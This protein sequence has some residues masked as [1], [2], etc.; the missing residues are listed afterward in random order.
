MSMIEPLMRNSTLLVDKNFKFVGLFDPGN[1]LL[2]S[3]PLSDYR[4]SS[5]VYLDGTDQH[6]Q[7]IVALY[8]HFR[9]TFLSLIKCHLSQL[10]SFKQLGS[11]KI[12]MQ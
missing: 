1:N 6:N 11:I 12:K 4:T 5:L 3:L 10:I 9:L 8:Y 7:T 2:I